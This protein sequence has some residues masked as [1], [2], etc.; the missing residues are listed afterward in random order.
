MMMMIMILKMIMIIIIMMMMTICLVNNIKKGMKRIED[1]ITL[2][3]FNY[4]FTE[5]VNYRCLLLVSQM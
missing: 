5:R 3:V 4:Y 1:L 2:S